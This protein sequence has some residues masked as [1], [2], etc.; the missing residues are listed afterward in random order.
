MLLIL[1]AAICPGRG[2]QLVLRVGGGVALHAK[3][4]HVIGSDPEAWLHLCEC[5]IKRSGIIVMQ[6]TVTER[7]MLRY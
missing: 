2:G 6:H 4:Q 1:I 5:A 3:L 7:A